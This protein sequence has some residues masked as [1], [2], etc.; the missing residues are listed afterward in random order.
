MQLVIGTLMLWI[1]NNVEVLLETVR[2]W[3]VHRK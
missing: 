2:L 3:L 1:S